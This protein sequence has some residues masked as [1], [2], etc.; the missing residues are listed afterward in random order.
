[1]RHS[2]K[3]VVGTAGGVLLW[4]WLLDAQDRSLIPLFRLS[5][6]RGDS[7]TTTDSSRRASSPGGSSPYRYIGE[8]GRVYPT[9]RPGTIPLMLWFS[10][11]RGDY[12]TTTDPRWRSRPVE[13][14][15]HFV[16]IQ[17][18][19]Y[20]PEAPQ[21]PGTLPLYSAWSPSREDNLLAVDTRYKGGYF[22]QRLSEADYEF[23]RVEGFILPAE[24]AVLPT[25]RREE[26]PSNRFPRNQATIGNSN[27]VSVRPLPGYYITCNLLQMEFIRRPVWAGVLTF[28]GASPAEVDQH[29]SSLARA[30]AAVCGNDG[31]GLRSVVVEWRR[32][33]NTLDSRLAQRL[34]IDRFEA[35]RLR[36]AGLGAERNLFREQCLSSPAGGVTNVG[37]F[38][39]LMA[40][41]RFP[42]TPNLTGN[43]VVPIEAALG[44]CRSGS[45]Q[46]P[47]QGIDTR[48]NQDAGG[49]PNFIACSAGIKA[50]PNLKPNCGDPAADEEGTGPP[51]PSGG[52]GTKEP[53]SRP[54]VELTAEQVAAVSQSG[55]GQEAVETAAA[56]ARLAGRSVPVMNAPPDLFTQP[57]PARPSIE[58]IRDVVQSVRGVVDVSD[59]DGVW[60]LTVRV[61]EARVGGGVD[62]TGTRGEISVGTRDGY[63]ISLSWQ[64]GSGGLVFRGPIR[65]CAA[66]NPGVTAT[67]PMGYLRSASNP[68]AGYVTKTDVVL[69]CLCKSRN[70]AAA[71]FA[72]GGLRSLGVRSG[73]GSNEIQ[74]RAECA[75]SGEIRSS[76]PDGL[77][78]KCAQMLRDDNPRARAAIFCQS[79]IQCP[80]L[81]P[82]AFA[83]A[84]G[85]F[86]C[87]CGVEGAI[88]PQ[89]NRS[90]P[91]GCLTVKCAPGDTT[92]PCCTAGSRASAGPFAPSTPRRR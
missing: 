57:P 55:Q 84:A 10:E 64:P 75:Q 70:R 87:G 31:P 2:R 48:V 22:R 44:N 16:G 1:M 82:V 39:T 86:M 78:P 88:S 62:S 72:S 35:A 68:T 40:L 37:V 8:E 71:N 9:S 83:A 63:E 67:H 65:D 54:S 73:C 61:G 52:S 49:T 91:L 50:A 45:S 28:Y 89:N 85:S 33:L 81:R 13:T 6:A 7:L 21:P 4:G 27:R 18:Y 5:N 24:A 59:R 41:G 43:P 20:D 34:H 3:W 26:R 42:Q 90:R 56:A 30:A 51:A 11:T 12:F 29:G 53:S 47:Y 36:E 80:Q 19:I 74:K 58:A 76:T 15:Y 38:D 32:Q 92:S 25:L 77:S 17:G 14:S 23:V 46:G 60:K 69:L 79:V 66:T